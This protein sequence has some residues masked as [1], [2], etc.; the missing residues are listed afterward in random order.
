MKPFKL[1][2]LVILTIIL[3]LLL[4]FIQFFLIMILRD[5]FKYF[6]FEFAYFFTPFCV[7]VIYLVYLFFC[8]IKFLI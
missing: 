1:L 2:S 3:P 5:I 8:L 4:G 7:G 6:K